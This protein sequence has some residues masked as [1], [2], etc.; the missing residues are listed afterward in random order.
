[1]ALSSF[2]RGVVDVFEFVEEVLVVLLDGSLS[3][4]VCG[5]GG[6]CLD[7]FILVV[8]GVDEGFGLDEVEKVCFL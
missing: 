8:V 5:S 6:C 7:S 3:E 2:G 1:M 4:G